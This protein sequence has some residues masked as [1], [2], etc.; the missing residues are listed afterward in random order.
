MSHIASVQQLFGQTCVLKPDPF[1]NCEVANRFQLNHQCASSLAV[2]QQLQL[3]FHSMTKRDFV[4]IILNF[5]T[6][7]VV[8]TTDICKM[9]CQSQDQLDD[10]KYQ[11][12]LW[13]QSTEENVFTISELLL[14]DVFV[15]DIITG[16]NAV[17]EALQLKS[18]LLSNLRF[19]EALIKTQAQLKVLGVHWCPITDEFTYHINVPQL[20]ITKLGNLLT[21]TRLFDPCVMVWVKIFLQTLWTLDLEWDQPLPEET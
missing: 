14:R 10:S 9:Y 8:F 21:I 15:D 13:H 3:A 2:S 11:C 17:E 1:K 18:E 5:R 12:I 19:S 16:A 6:M 20:S 4:N 7:A